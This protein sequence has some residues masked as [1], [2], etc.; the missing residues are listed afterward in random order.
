MAE[1]R[2]LLVE[3]G[4]EELPPLALEALSKGFQ[5]SLTEALDKAGLSP[6]ASQ[7]FATP[8]RIAVLFD[9]VMMSQ[10]D[11]VIERRGPALAAAYDDQG[12]PTAAAKGFA[13]SC[14]VTVEALETLSTDRGEWLLHRHRAPGAKAAELIPGLLQGVLAK[15]PIPKRMRWGDGDDEF[16]RPLHWLVILLG[17]EVVPATIMGI[18]SGRYTRGHRFHHPA[19]IYLAD[20]T[21][22]A[23]LLETEGHVLAD[24]DS[25]RRAIRGQVQEAAHQV[26]GGALLDGPLLD[27]V[28]ALVEWPVAMTGAFDE[29]FLEVPHEALISSMQDHQKYFP[30][31]DQAGKLLP[32]FVTVA[33]LES[34][35]PTQVVLGNQRVLRARL[36]DAEFFWQQDCKIRLSHRRPRLSTMMF[37]HKLGSLAD[38]TDR[39]VALVG[40]IAALT[41]K[42]ELSCQR[43]AELCKCDLLTMMVYEFPELQGIMG[44][45]YALHDGESAAVALAISEHYLPRFA[46]D[47]LPSSDDGRLLALADRLDTLVG[48]FSIGRHPTGA[49]DPFALR[50]SA[51]AVLRI[52]IDTPPDLSLRH[53]LDTAA[54]GFPKH[55]QAQ[56]TVSK[57]HDFIVERL[58][59]NALEQGFHA[60]EFDAVLA[61]EPVA[62]RDF[63]GRLKA[64]AEFRKL[65]QAASLEIANKRI[66]NILRRSDETIPEE[67]DEALLIEAPEQE[68]AA[69]VARM[70]AQVQPLIESGN[71]QEALTR[72]AAL[73]PA[74]DGFFDHVLVMAEDPQLRANRLAILQ[75]L[76]T[77]FLWVADFSRL[78]RRS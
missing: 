57:L 72:L 41:D 13:R 78:Q 44:R 30:V 48:I 74:V 61:R 26:G 66:R 3:L 71:Y 34:R 69:S 45:H 5:D 73:G 10:E 70:A 22:Y 15:L 29:R 6:A 60:D 75:Q 19:P 12:E 64:V 8:R 65:P 76:E 27:E 21:T 54:A 43:A 58:R 11:R 52:L 59:A 16:I 37:E 49:S 46:G 31:V 23:S 40:A 4:T 42:P 67:I 38:K 56:Q 24:H 39:V 20:P 25:R 18:E 77:L 51:L 68:L 63:A 14:A 33:N 55:I 53:L 28:T 9:E 7:R 62:P 50:R 1:T 35:D 17:S 2:S 36:A 47:V 32:H